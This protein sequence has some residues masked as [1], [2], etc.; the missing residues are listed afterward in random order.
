MK[1]WKDL[2]QK[3]KQ[4]YIDQIKKIIQ[5]VKKTTENIELPEINWRRFFYRNIKHAPQLF[6]LM[7]FMFVSLNTYRMVV[8][9]AELS[10][11]ESNHTPTS[12]INEGL[13][14]RTLGSIMGV[15]LMLIVVLGVFSAF[16]FRGRRR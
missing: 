15:G 7:L 9:S 10:I 6:I 4:F 14:S 16:T 12:D 3:E 8:E 2:W 5:P 13:M 1:L 11:A